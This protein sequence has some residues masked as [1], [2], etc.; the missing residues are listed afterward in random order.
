M[1]K[2]LKVAFITIFLS[3]TFFL[4]ISNV[5]A[6]YVNAN[7]FD[8]E[9]PDFT[10]YSNYIMYYS[11]FGGS[12]GFKVFACPSSCTFTASTSSTYITSSNPYGIVSLWNHFGDGTNSNSRDYTLQNGQW[13]MR[14][15]NNYGNITI[16]NKGANNN[17]FIIKT[18]GNIYPRFG[19]TSSTPYYEAGYEVPSD[20]DFS[21]AVEQGEVIMSNSGGV[22]NNL[23]SY[24]LEYDNTISN[25]N[26]YYKFYYTITTGGGAREGVRFY[27]KYDDSGFIYNNEIYHYYYN[28]PMAYNAQI[29]YTIYDNEDNIVK[30]E[31]VNAYLS[32]LTSLASY[33][34]YDFTNYN[35]ANM[36]YINSDMFGV[37]SQLNGNLIINIINY[38]TGVKSNFLT[39]SYFISSHIDEA[40]IT[41]YEF[42][43]N[44]E[45]LY[46]EIINDMANQ[47]DIPRLLN[48]YDLFLY[49]PSSSYVHLSTYPINL[50]TQSFETNQQAYKDSN[51]DIIYVNNNIIFTP[52][53]TGDFFGNLQKYFSDI[54][55]FHSGLTGIITSPLNLIQNLLTPVCSGLS[56]PLPYINSTLTLPCMETI[57][58]QYFG[59]FFTLYQNITFGVIAYW[60]IIRILRMVKDFRSP[61]HDEIEVLDL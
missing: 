11:D 48:T 32:S 28:L 8:L 47:V 41:W 3:V 51:G 18:T 15:G 19:N 43:F 42:D 2:S 30:S 45:P 54:D 29:T 9:L 20:L 60:V 38:T 25:V 17:A 52:N 6:L 26:D 50:D 57:Y 14:S 44:N 16:T 33:D 59:S 10:A 49:F 36:S 23:V 37:S 55:N 53:N 61:D 21:T 24:Y 58:S 13:V 5:N 7:G 56:V 22:I 35:V 31:N 1:K 39:S 27:M 40:G 34:M 12:E 46:L 4:G